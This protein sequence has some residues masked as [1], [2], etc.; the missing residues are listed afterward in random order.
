MTD[1]FTLPVNGKDY[2]I[3]S[4][5]AKVGLALQAS[6]AIT[7]ARKAKVDPPEYALERAAR[8]DSHDRSMDEDSLSG[9]GPDGTTAWDRMLEDDVPLSELR[10]AAKAAYVWIVT[11][12]ADSARAF[13]S[14]GAQ[15]GASGPKAGTT[16]A[17]ATT[18]RR[19]APGTTTTSR[20]KSTG[21]SGGKRK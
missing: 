4:P 2:E 12:S 18:T 17:A 19:R 11:G 3:F 7:L 15:E 8:Y 5:P 1:S 10:R 16:T 9:K 6:Y 14:G 21:G 20:K 13:M